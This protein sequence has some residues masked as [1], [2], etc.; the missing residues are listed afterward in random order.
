[1][2]KQEWI[3]TFDDQMWCADESFET[4]EEAIEA[5]RKEAQKEE[6]FEEYSSFFVGT[7]HKLDAQTLSDR[8]TMVDIESINDQVASELGGEDD[9][10]EIGK[11]Y[12]KFNELNL[13]V[14]DFILKN[15]NTSMSWFV[16]DTEEVN[17]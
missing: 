5:G 1:M 16:E 17:L 6:N 3:F 9:Y 4:K 8:I 7:Q 12:P 10:V 13:Y 11:D 2:E 15:F 14:A